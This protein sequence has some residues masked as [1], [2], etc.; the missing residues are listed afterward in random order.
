MTKT[1]LTFVFRYNLPVIIIVINNNGIYGG[2][3]QVT[4][5][6]IREDADPTQV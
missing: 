6:A 5:N 3:D 4:Y 2:F 1:D